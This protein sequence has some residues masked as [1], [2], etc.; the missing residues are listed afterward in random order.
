MK[1]RVTNASLICL[2]LVVILQD[3]D[4]GQGVVASQKQRELLV[5]RSLRASL[6]PALLKKEGG[7]NTDPHMC[8]ATKHQECCRGRC[9]SLHTNA[10]NC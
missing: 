3:I 9:R 8:D 4:G 7:C 10:L 2:L 5:K 1:R 6:L